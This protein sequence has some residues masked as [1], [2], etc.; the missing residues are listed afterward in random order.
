MRVVDLGALAWLTRPGGLIA[1]ATERGGKGAG[2]KRILLPLAAAV[3]ML[4]LAAPAYG[5]TSGY[6]PTGCPLPANIDLGAHNIG[7]VFGGVIGGTGGGFSVGQPAV[8][9][10]NGVGAGTKLP[11]SNGCIAATFH[12]LS[13]PRVDVDDV[14]GANCGR[15]VMVASQPGH[16]GSIVFTINC[17]AAAAPAAAGRVAFTGANVLRWGLAALALIGVGVLLV[18]GARRRRVTV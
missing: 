2:M 15:N 3:M 9:T 12:V 7:D 4:G 10:I 8:I 16:Q 6:P 18:L 11:D 1:A 17:A 5:Q 13:G 14:V